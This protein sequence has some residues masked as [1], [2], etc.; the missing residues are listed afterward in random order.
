MSPVTLP[1]CFYAGAD[2]VSRQGVVLLEDLGAAGVAFGNATRPIGADQVAV[3]LNAVAGFHASTWGAR[4]SLDHEFV[5]DGIPTERPKA[6]WFLNA[7][8]DVFRHYIAERAEANTPA[9]VND[10]DRIVRAFWQLA[11]MSRDEPVCLIHSDAHLDN[12][13][14]L[15]NGAPGLLDW[16]SPRMSSWAWD[17]SYF[18]ISA[19]TID[20]RRRSEPRPA[21][22]Y[23]GQLRSHGVEC[24]DVRCGVAGLPAME[25][26][27]LVREDR[28]PRLL[29]AAGDH[30]AW[31][32]RH[33][34]AA[35]DLETF[36]S[37]GL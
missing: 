31:M 22:H 5:T 28:Q 10:P 34:A 13:Y 29:Q 32:S 18:V 3:V 1:R 11:A 15:P 21:R 2:P 37:L 12:W 6:A 19:L 14:F 35:E 7:T 27:R 16:C 17:V 9:S 33:V 26:V 20:E 30:V 8:P 25:R 24:A 4:W 36:E 23:L